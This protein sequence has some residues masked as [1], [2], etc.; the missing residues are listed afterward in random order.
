MDHI[1]LR[2]HAHA[3]HLAELRPPL[4]F[5]SDTA[6]LDCSVVHVFDTESGAVVLSFLTARGS[7]NVS[8]PAP[9]AFELADGVTR[10]TQARCRPLPTGDR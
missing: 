4:T 6:D 8:L 10:L 5:Q 9:L 7:I 1:R 2:R 3:H